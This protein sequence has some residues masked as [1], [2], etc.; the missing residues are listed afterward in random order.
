M[1]GGSLFDDKPAAS[2]APAAS[3]S[4][5]PEAP[6]VKSSV[7]LTKP[8]DAQLTYGKIKLPPGTALRLISHDG[9]MVK[10]MYLNNVL[11]IPAASTDIDAPPAAPPTTSIPPPPAS[12]Q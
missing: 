8:F 4:L 5:V 2:G 9:G 12:L 6:Q 3:T 10:A 11:T 1:A 7:L